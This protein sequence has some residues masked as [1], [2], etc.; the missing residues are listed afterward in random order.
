MIS[1]DF[2]KKG[3]FGGHQSGQGQQHGLQKSGG[4]RHLGPPVRA[5]GGWGSRLDPDS[6]V[7]IIVKHDHDRFV[8]TLLA[9]R[10]E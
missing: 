10:P 9:T 6:P 3:T 4:N 1:L 8:Q 7:Q 5:K 2:P